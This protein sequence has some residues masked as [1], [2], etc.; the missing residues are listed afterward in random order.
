MGIIEELVEIWP[1][2]V[3]DRSTVHSRND[4]GVESNI[5]NRYRVVD[6]LPSVNRWSNGKDESE[7]RTIPKNFHRSQTRTMARLVGN[8]K[9]CI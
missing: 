7:L 5:G 6:S 9:V 4:E 3:C 8:G 2:E 1:N